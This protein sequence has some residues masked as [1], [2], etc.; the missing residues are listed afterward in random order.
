MGS[1]ACS[2]GHHLT[3]RCEC[4]AVT[5][6]LALADGCSLLN[7]RRAFASRA[8]PRWGSPHIAQTFLQTAPASDGTL[9]PAEVDMRHT[10]ISGHHGTVHR[11][12]EATP[13]SKRGQ[14]WAGVDTDS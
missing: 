10:T 11:L 4:S 6:G 1:I 14:D 2:C 8:S 13:E 12:L 7:G 3:W 5:Y 9:I